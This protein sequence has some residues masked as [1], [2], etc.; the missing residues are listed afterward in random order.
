MANK[1]RELSV[2]ERIPYYYRFFGKLKDN[3]I[4]RTNAEEICKIFGFKSRSTVTQNIFEILGKAGR[5]KYGYNTN[6]V[7]NSLQQILQLDTPC[8]AY[9]VGNI[10]P[11]MESD[12]IKERNIV[13]TD[14]EP[15]L[16]RLLIITDKS[17]HDISEILDRHPEIEKIINFTENK[18]ESGEVPI[19]NFDFLEIM[20][21]SLKIPEYTITQ[22]NMD[23]E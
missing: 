22:D 5:K 13:I 17:T 16:I 15:D 4:K 14:Q 7:Y 2:K 19:L 1:Y 20:L 21:S 6:Y 9:V 3:K 11:F 10:L 23:E 8:H 18:Y 12:E